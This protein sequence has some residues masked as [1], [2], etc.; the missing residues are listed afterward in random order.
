MGVS[1]F[2]EHC[3][4]VLTRL[5]QSEH[6]AVVVGAGAS[7]AAQLPGWEELIIKLLS[8]GP[9]QRSRRVAD[10]LASTQGYLLAAE[11]ALPPSFSASRRKQRVAKAL[12]GTQPRGSFIPSELHQAIALLASER[13]VTALQI[14]TTNYDDLLEQALRDQGLKCRSRYSAK[15]VAKKDEIGV[16]HIHGYLGVNEES[17]DI[18]LG[19]S[20]YARITDRQT[21]WPGEEIA[22]AAA[23]GPVVFVGASLTDPNLVQILERIRNRDFERHVLV[24]ARQGL[25]VPSELR[26]PFAERLT[27]QWHRYNV[28]VVL[29]DDFCDVSLF[30]R[31]ITTAGD[32]G[33]VGPAERVAK[34]WSG[35]SGNFRVAQ[36]EFAE[37]LDAGFS[38][39]LLP[40]VGE[41]ANLV[42]WLSNGEGSMIRF[43]ANDRLFRSPAALRRIPDRH[44]AGWVVSEAI[45]FETTAVRDVSVTAGPESRVPDRRWLSIAAVP[46]RPVSAGFGPTV[47]GALSAATVKKDLDSSMLADAL[48]QIAAEWEV[49]LGQLNPL[50]K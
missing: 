37:A 8:K 23:K 10:L 35:I 50:R 2:D 48:N 17:D 11:A 47:V 42:L 20:D 32:E 36:E 45:S 5:A 33:F 25:G 15:N 38:Q 13:G 41:E 7:I 3:N 28:D 27:T 43:A 9:G 24:V 1:S 14:F 22:A 31:E 30:V 26:D 18:V 21:D 19:Q 16:H 34:L 44:D 4:A 40:I 46:L 29:L 12:F 49:R 39:H 6:L